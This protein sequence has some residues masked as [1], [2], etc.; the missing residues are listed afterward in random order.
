VGEGFAIRRVPFSD[1]DVAVLVDEVQ[2]EYVRRY[3]GPDRT[4]VDASV[5]DPPAGAF[6]LGHLDGRPVAMG[7]WRRRDDVDAFP[8]VPVAEIKRMY[9]VPHARRLGL[10]RRVL[11]HLEDSARA[12]GAPVLVLETGVEQPEAIALYTS[13]GYAR[14]P[15]FG[16]YRHS[17]KNRC[18]AKRLGPGAA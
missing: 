13:E 5:F 16:L 18:F 6:F 11:R 3:G 17:P 4:P 8:G 9:V 1:P 10:A 2:Q 7:G 14:I 12:A 15:G